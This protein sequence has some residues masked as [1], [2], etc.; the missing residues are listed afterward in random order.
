[1]RLSPK[2]IR[3]A[4]LAVTFV[5]APVALGG[6]G[7]VVRINDALCEKQVGTCCPQVGSLCNAGSGDNQHYYYKES[8]PC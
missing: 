2:V 1:M 3:A 4:A 7:A 6:K 8:G 5:A